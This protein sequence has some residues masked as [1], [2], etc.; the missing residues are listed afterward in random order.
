[1]LR[2]ISQWLSLCKWAERN[3]CYD[4]CYAVSHPIRPLSASVGAKERVSATGSNTSPHPPQTRDS[5]PAA[6]SFRAFA[7]LRALRAASRHEQ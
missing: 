3:V 6:R 2:L 7:A 5:R 1:M 4:F